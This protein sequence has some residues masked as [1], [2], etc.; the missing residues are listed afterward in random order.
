MT[1]GMER[2]DVTPA[3]D[4]RDVFIHYPGVCFVV[5]GKTHLISIKCYFTNKS[6]LKDLCVFFDEVHT[7]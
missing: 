1:V 6:E 2:R 5:H 7:V 4:N 3:R